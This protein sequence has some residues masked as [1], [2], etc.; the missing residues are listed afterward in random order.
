MSAQ[1]SVYLFR[2]RTAHLWQIALV[3][4]D[5]L[6]LVIKLPDRGQVKRERAMCVN[7]AK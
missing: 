2:L 4:M 7:R 1:P 6:V 3:E 5:S